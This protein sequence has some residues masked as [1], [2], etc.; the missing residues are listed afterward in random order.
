MFCATQNDL[1]EYNPSH[2][3]MIPHLHDH[4]H[5]PPPHHSQP[6]HSLVLLHQKTNQTTSVVFSAAIQ[7]DSMSDLEGATSLIIAK[8]FIDFKQILLAFMNTI[9]IPTITPLKTSFTRPHNVLL[10]IPNLPLPAVPSQLHLHLNQ[11]AL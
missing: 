11:V 4:P 3:N 7:T 2:S 10:T 5:Q 9:W 6:T 8:K 1:D